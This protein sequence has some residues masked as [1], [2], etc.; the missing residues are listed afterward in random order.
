MA[1]LAVIGVG[2]LL[3]KRANGFFIFVGVSLSRLVGK[4]AA[5][6]ARPLGHL[7]MLFNSWQKAPP[8]SDE[9]ITQT[10][11]RRHHPF[12]SRTHHEPLPDLRQTHDVE[13]CQPAI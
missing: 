2:A 13:N 6:P 4:M 11:G 3:E 8:F 10:A 5:A 12:R 9:K 7:P 1:A